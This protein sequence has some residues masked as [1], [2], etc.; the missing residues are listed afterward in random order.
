MAGSVE[1]LAA[2]ADAS[3]IAVFRVPLVYV[4]NK[5]ILTLNTSNKIMYQQRMTIKN[6]YKKILEP[7]MNSINRFSTEHVHLVMQIHFSDRRKRDMDNQI[8]MLK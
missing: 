6:K 5:T 3:D 4:K 8:F 2:I 1:K 7:I